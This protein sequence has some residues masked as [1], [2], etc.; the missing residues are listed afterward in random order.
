MEETDRDL[1]IRI[2]KILYARSDGTPAGILSEF[3]K[4]FVKSKQLKNSD[5]KEADHPR[6]DA[7]KFTDKGEGSG[8]KTTQDIQ[9]KDSINIKEILGTEYKGIKGK[10][11]INLLMQKRTGWVAD[12]FYRKEIGNISLIWGDLRLGLCHIINHREAQG[13]NIEDFLSDITEVI[14][15]GEIIR[16][17]PKGRYEIKLGRKMAIIE[18]KE[19]NGQM[20]LLL[21]AY[22]RRK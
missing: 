4:A 17:S 12:A 3:H 9:G 15:Q 8:I 11:A 6:D 5:F 19:T 1:A 7:G 13:I 22:K 20:T 16:F 10:L 2:F 18:P 21:T 14:E